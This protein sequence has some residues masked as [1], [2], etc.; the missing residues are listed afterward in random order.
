MTAFRT[1]RHDFTLFKANSVT[2]DRRIPAGNW[3]VLAYRRGSTSSQ[4]KNIGTTGGITL[5][6]YE[7]GDIQVNDT[8]TIY[9]AVGSP[10]RTV[11]AIAAGLLT[12]GV[13][14]TGTFNPGIGARIVPLNNRPKTFLHTKQGSPETPTASQA[15]T[16][17][18]GAASF[19][20]LQRVIDCIATDNAGNTVMIRDQTGQGA[21][22][23]S[24]FQWNA[25]GDGVADDAAAFRAVIARAAAEGIQR[26]VIP[27]GIY[28][29]NSTITLNAASG[30]TFT[31]AVPGQVTIQFAHPSGAGFDLTVGCSDISFED[32]LFNTSASGTSII[33]TSTTNF[34]LACRRCTFIVGSNRTGIIEQGTDARFE[35]CLLVGSTPVTWIRLNGAIRPQ[36][37]GCFGS[38][39]GNASGRVIDIDTGCRGVRLLNVDLKG[40]TTANSAASGVIGVRNSAAG[41]APRDIMLMGCH[42]GAGTT[43][44]GVDID[45]VQG[46]QSI[47][48]TIEDSLKGYSIDGG[49]SI[50]II[51]G[52]CVGIQ[53]ESVDING[54]NH[55]R[56]VEL[57]SSDVSQA[58][59]GTFNHVD[60]AA[61]LDDISINGLTAG[62]FVRASGIISRAVVEIQAGASDRIMLNQIRGVLAD[63][64]AFV[65]NQSTSQDMDVGHVMNSTA[66]LSYSHLGLSAEP[67]HMGNI[68]DKL[69]SG[70]ETTTSVQNIYELTFSQSAPTT[71]I[72]LTSGTVGQNVVCHFLNGNTTF[73][74]T[75]NFKLSTTPTTWTS[76]DT[77]TL[78]W[79]V[80][81]AKWL[82]VARSVNTA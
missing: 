25:V 79:D 11:S 32:I 18:F 22:T 3:D 35:N 14:G 45:A 59:A 44:R 33:Q 24:P 21:D 56:I 42:L 26:I 80:T 75:G 70:V 36:I 41:T 61:G 4:S 6:V 23:E 31:A 5:T 60:I 46:F 81:A 54:G 72:S 29:I 12:F 77:I 69:L 52:L 55:I 58:S 15:T 9:N 30:L 2:D 57:E 20:T 34:R 78:S 73:N 67:A 40:N 8:V 48:C 37:T 39:S 27:P 10:T 74:E 49:S 1:Y 71:F 65:I 13:G 66:G 76:N 53:N 47:G 64:T 7:C 16:D 50:K 68:N 17:S 19:Y 43:G 38:W 28:L 63:V 51:G 82:E 62:N